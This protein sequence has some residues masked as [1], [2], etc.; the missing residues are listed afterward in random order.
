[1]EVDPI[2]V[3]Q[4][5]VGQALRKDRSA[6]LN[7]S[8]NFGLQLADRRFEVSVNQGGV[9]ANRLQ[10]SRYDPFRL[11]PP[12]VGKF[13]PW[14]VPFGMILVPIAHDFIEVAAVDAARLF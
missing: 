2:F 5:K 4:A 7:L 9:G 13:A 14:L 3:D 1:M 8:G 10:R 12:R 6:N 11:A